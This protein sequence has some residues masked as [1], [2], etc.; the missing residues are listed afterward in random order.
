MDI[1]APNLDHNGVDRNRLSTVSY[2]QKW[3]VLKPFMHSLYSDLDIGPLA[4]A[5]TR[6]YGFTAQ[7]VVDLMQSLMSMDEF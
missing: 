3:D 5:V 6:K 7:Y 2:D 4:E 1:P